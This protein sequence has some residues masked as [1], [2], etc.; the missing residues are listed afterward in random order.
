MALQRG[1]PRGG[2]GGRGPGRMVGL[3][4]AW[5]RGPWGSGVS[6]R[7]AVRG[8]NPENTEPRRVRCPP[9]RRHS[10]TKGI[11]VA[12]V[13]TFFEAFNVP[14]FW[15]ILVMYFIMLFCITMKRQIKVRRRRRARK[16]GACYGPRRV[17]RAGGHVYLPRLHE[18]QEA[19]QAW[20]Q[21]TGSLPA[22]SSSGPRPGRGMGR[23]DGLG[24]SRKVLAVPPPGH[25]SCGSE[26]GPADQPHGGQGASHPGPSCAQPSGPT[27]GHLDEACRQSL[28]LPDTCLI[29]SPAHDQ[30]PVHPVH[31]RQED[32]QGEGGRGQDVRELDGRGR[33]S[34]PS[35]FEPL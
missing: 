9:S 25:E 27:G 26:P 30:V 23:A 8:G 13:C 21:E 31:A 11:L 14:V 18:R 32:I 34:E 35:A 20:G 17:G 7:T 10:A 16:G 19:L 2:S 33:P 28:L 29:P 3:G 15:P 22:A 24:M 12:M 6:T 5:P 1:E 4:A